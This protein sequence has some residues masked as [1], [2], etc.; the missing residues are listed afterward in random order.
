MVTHYGGPCLQKHTLE[1][2]EMLCIYLP[3]N[4]SFTL[5]ISSPMDSWF[6]SYHKINFNPVSPITL[7]IVA[8]KTYM[9]N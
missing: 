9:T 7:A 3:Y 6:A 8:T 4:D 5:K 2:H 1:F